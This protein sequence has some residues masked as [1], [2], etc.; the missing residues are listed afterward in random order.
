MHYSPNFDNFSQYTFEPSA[1]IKP[2]LI[3]VSLLWAS[4]IV[5]QEYLEF[6]FAGTPAQLN[7]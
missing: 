3:E 2:K 4:K 7:S 5:F 6:S 1:I